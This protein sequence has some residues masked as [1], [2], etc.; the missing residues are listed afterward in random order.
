MFEKWVGDSNPMVDIQV[1][2]ANKALIVVWLSICIV[3]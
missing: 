1:D 3:L 2:A